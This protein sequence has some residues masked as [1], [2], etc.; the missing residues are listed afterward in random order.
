M[1]ALPVHLAI[2]MDGNG[3]WA[4][5]RRM[6]RL[7]GHKA[8]AETVRRVI[9]AAPGLGVRTLTLYAFSSDN[10]KRPQA[11]VTGL[12]GLLSDFLQRETAELVRKGVRFTAIGR[13]DRLSA[14]LVR[15]IEMCEESTRACAELHLRVAIDY[16]SRDALLS[17]ARRGAATREQVAE[18]LGGVPDVDILVRTGGEKRLSDFLLWECAYAELYF[19]DIMWPDFTIDN[20]RQALQ[21]FHRR[22][23][24]FGRIPMAEAI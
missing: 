21:K 9:E 13:R 3:R 11:E 7:A 10:W 1:S 20:L 17:A 8:G 12:F 4:T 18:M 15:L 2:I 5:A 24:R 6:P 16:S 19:T 14:P 22:Q 23:R